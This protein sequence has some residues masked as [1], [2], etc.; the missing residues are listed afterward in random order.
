MGYKVDLHLLS[1][2]RGDVRTSKLNYAK[3]SS[4]LT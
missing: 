3:V 2:E 1:L 4:M